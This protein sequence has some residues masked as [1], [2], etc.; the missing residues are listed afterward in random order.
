M[1][2]ESEQ[3]IDQFELIFSQ[4]NE[5]EKAKRKSKCDLALEVAK[6]RQ[7]KKQLEA[8]KRAVESTREQTI[9][10]Q[11]C[12]TNEKTRNSALADHLRAMAAETKTMI[13]DAPVIVKHLT[14][15]MKE[16]QK[17]CDQYRLELQGRKAEGKQIRDDFQARAEPVR[18]RLEQLRSESE[19][20][21][22]KLSGYQPVAK[23]EKSLEEARNSLVALQATEKKNKDSIQHLQL[24]LNQRIQAKTIGPLPTAAD[25]RALLEKL[26]HFATEK[27]VHQVK[28]FMKAAVA[29][30]MC[31]NCCV[32]S[33][34]A[35]DIGL[36]V[37]N[38]AAMSTDE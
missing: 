4:L 9:L 37:D 27:N 3:M 16:K 7:L 30:N 20:L 12:L 6:E 38:P 24:Q 25:T 31:F 10:M 36:D 17:E 29:G 15:T 13:T 14:A 26:D 22:R 23:L 21:E 33:S 2:S 1:A 32:E 28:E 34:N 11:R 5:W 35:A 18:T 19:S 8:S